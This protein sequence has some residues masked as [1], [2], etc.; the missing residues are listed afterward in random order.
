MEHEALLRSAHRWLVLA[1]V[2]L[3]LGV[4][5]LSWTKL[6]LGQGGQGGPGSS[7]T[8]VCTGQLVQSP[9]MAWAKSAIEFS[10]PYGP[11]IVAPLKSDVEVLNGPLR[12]ELDEG[13]L[14][15]AEPQPRMPSPEGNAL[16]IAQLHVSRQT[17]RFSLRAEMSR[18]SSGLLLGTAVWEGACAPESERERKF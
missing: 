15:A 9:G 10:L 3:V 16:R 11:G 13:A 8:L 6:S 5:M 2:A 1:V 12:I 7:G 14:K 17:G 4:G 18:E